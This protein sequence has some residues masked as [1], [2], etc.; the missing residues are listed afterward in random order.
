MTS[1]FFRSVEWTARLHYNLIVFYQLKRSKKSRGNTI[2]HM[3]PTTQINQKLVTKTLL[4]SLDQLCKVGRYINVKT[5]KPNSP[6][7]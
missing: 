3:D 6:L 7:G 4:G 2:Q 1:E 5:P